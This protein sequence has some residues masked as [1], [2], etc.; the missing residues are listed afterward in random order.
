MTKNTPVMVK[1]WI[2]ALVNATALLLLCSVAW[3]G[4]AQA[5]DETVSSPS[6]LEMAFA[7]VSDKAKTPQKT[8]GCLIVWSTANPST[9]NIYCRY[10]LGKKPFLR[11]NDV[12]FE[13]TQNKKLQKSNSKKKFQGNIQTWF[14][15]LY[16][17]LKLAQDDL[18][19]IADAMSRTKDELSLFGPKTFRLALPASSDTTT[20]KKF[21][22][23]VHKF[24]LKENIP[25]KVATAKTNNNNAVSK[26]AVAAQIKEAVDKL[27]SELPT[28]PKNA[29][30]E[31]TKGETH[32]HLIPYFF[33]V[34]IVVVSV[35]IFVLLF[36]F[37]FK[38]K[39][40]RLMDDKLE[41]HFSEKFS[42]I[43]KDI[44][45]LKTQLR[46]SG[47]PPGEVINELKT[48][49][50]PQLENEVRQVKDTLSSIQSQQK[51]EE[52][53][54]GHL[55]K[56]VARLE[57]EKSQSE[58]ALDSQKPFMGWA[59][60]KIVS[61]FHLEQPTSDVADYG[62]K[63]TQTQLKA[64]IEQAIKQHESEKQ[65][66]HNQR[67]AVIKRV[68]KEC[69]LLGEAAA[70]LTEATPERL[71][72]AVGLAI[73]HHLGETKATIAQQLQTV[74][75]TVIKK[76]SLETDAQETAN[77]NL[78]ATLAQLK[79]VVDE[80]NDK[81]DSELK[82]LTNTYET[83]VQEFLS[84]RFL[85][86]KPAK[87]QA[88]LAWITTLK[89]QPGVWRWLQP[90]LLGEWLVCKPIV[91]GLK[92]NGNDKEHKIADDLL[93]LDSL[94]THWADLVGWPFKSND[95]L[96]K[97]LYNLDGRQWLNHLLRAHDVLQT[98]F[99][100]EEKFKP[101]SQHLSIV[102][103][104]LLA[105]FE[106]MGITIL[107]PEILKEVPKDIPQRKDINYL[108]NPPDILKTLVEPQVQ[109]MI[110]NNMSNFVVDI[111]RYGFVTKN[112]QKSKAKADVQVVLCNPSDW[113]QK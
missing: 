26:D 112:H 48:R 36:L 63:S 11:D 110:R 29:D 1:G 55:F 47:A 66:A 43:G 30:Q 25:S 85:L 4:V 19:R 24:L 80:A 8:A 65:S 10:E 91:D 5:G 15:N 100:T 92:Q 9:Q 70:K 74:I 61:T 94:M 69:S 62:L 83:T 64:V 54:K 13:Q 75:S 57:Q 79:K 76:Y 84:E 16:P 60:R 95:D 90:A 51:T 2:S 45:Q 77:L 103:G 113:R 6:D 102:N 14:G 89:E 46:T 108:Y 56:Q 7:I 44:T 34:P 42:K 72:D 49:L 27:K 39:L 31:A 81:H 33:W 96:W 73:Q 20:D 37:I 18:S 71:E 106:K 68:I 53:E 50:L 59:V 99:P 87:Q 17:N 41:T 12:G 98:Y 21:A 107:R 88:F 104:L 93:H 38:N 78:E 67:Q 35:L 105:A 28:A 97:Y 32:S 101:L 82:T 52:T 109:E 111:E 40:T 3:V 58:Q 23:A 22:A 86:N